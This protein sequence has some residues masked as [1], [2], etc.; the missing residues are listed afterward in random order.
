VTPDSFSDGGQYQ[1]P[2]AALEHAA[3]MLEEGAD[4]IDVG[5]E[6]TRPQGAASVSLREEM[7]RVIPVIE[8]LSQRFP[9]SLI[10]VDTVKSRVAEAA[11]A[12][13]AHIVNDVS[14]FRLDQRMAAVCGETAAGVILMHSRGDVR[15]MATYQN[16]SYSDDPAGDV[17]GELL[18]AVELAVRG[19]VSSGAIALDPGIGFSKLSS[20]S[21]AI[22]RDLTLFSDL[23]YPLM[24]GVSRK[25]F[26]GELS[27][28]QEAAARVFGSVAAN[29]IALVNGAMLFRVHDVRATRQ[30]LDVAWGVLTV[31]EG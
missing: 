14:A 11:L 21:M 26:I 18:G 12:A 7:D 6:S 24:V 5:G 23:G 1:S 9:S 4:I 22:L 19:G 30:A 8:E 15:D 31:G 29:V 25:R 28:V 2:G 13:G 17:L 27:G 16:A 3:R 10:S 20:H